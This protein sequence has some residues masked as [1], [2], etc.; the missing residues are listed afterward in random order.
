MKVR[1]IHRQAKVVR[2]LVVSLVVQLV[3]EKVRK[4]ISIVRRS[5]LR[6]GIAYLLTKQNEHK[7]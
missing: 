1:V 7:T 5:K 6:V 4:E 3:E 2:Y